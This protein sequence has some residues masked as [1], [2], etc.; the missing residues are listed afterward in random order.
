MAM[1][2]A[3]YQFDK[4]NDGNTSSVR[5]VNVSKNESFVAQF[6]VADSTDTGDDEDHPDYI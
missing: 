1:P 3:G 2:N 5:T 4:W 6:K